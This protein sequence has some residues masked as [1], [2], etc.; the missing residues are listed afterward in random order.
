MLACPQGF[1]LPVP[2]PTGDRQAGLV[3]C[4][5]KRVCTV[6]S[7]LQ[8]TFPLLAATLPGG[9]IIPFYKEGNRVL[10]K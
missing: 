10:E 3:G 9:V 8:I 4:R 5:V 1:G 7:S 2:T 6:L